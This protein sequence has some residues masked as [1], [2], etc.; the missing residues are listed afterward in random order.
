MRVAIC[1]SNYIPWKGY[2]DLIHEVDIFV[3]YDDVQF[4]KNDWRNR[5]RIKTPHGPRW[6]TVPVGD[7]IKRLIC[8]VEIASDRWQTKHWKTLLQYYRHAA[9]FDCYEP[10]LRSVYVESEWR[11]L[12]ALNQHLIRRIAGECLGI[13]TRFIESASLG[14]TGRRQ[15]RVLALLCKLNADV[16]VTGPAARAYLEPARF[17]EAG[18]DLV[19]KDYVGYPE[20]RQFYPPF[21]H[22]VSILD[23]LFHTGP[24]APCYIWGRRN[25]EVTLGV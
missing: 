17:H 14:G 19:W 5:N 22:A 3:F 11:S 7:D 16:Y 9:F 13:T 2:F 6:L 21:Q 4:T 10:L 8:E 15:D 1:Q 25:M 23:L 24:D 12:S 18:I 20:Y